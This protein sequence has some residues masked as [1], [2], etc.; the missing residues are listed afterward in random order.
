MVR[1]KT[2]YFEFPWKSYNP[3]RLFCPVQVWNLQLSQVQ[4]SKFLTLPNSWR[5]QR[6]YILG[7]FLTRIYKIML[8]IRGSRSIEL[9]QHSINIFYIYYPL[10]DTYDFRML[11]SWPPVLEHPTF[12]GSNL[13]ESKLISNS[14]KLVEI[15]KNVYREVLFIEIKIILSV[16]I[17]GPCK[18]DWVNPTSNWSILQLL[19]IRMS[20]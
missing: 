15:L 9:I 18:A 13:G 2:S 19:L 10:Y 14:S 20:F 12:T 3:R 5:T 1:I 17:R 11:G 4:I 8:Y 7:G 6:L 16:Y